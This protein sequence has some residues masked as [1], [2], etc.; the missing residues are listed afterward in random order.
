[1]KYLEE[2]KSGDCFVYKEQ[3]FLLT[4]DFK[5]DGSRLCYSLVSGYPKW[6]SGQDIVE[7]LSIYS[8]DKDNN[9]IPIKT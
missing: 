6:L 3:N 1:M 4:S 7:P 2:L 5:R 8:L 9:I